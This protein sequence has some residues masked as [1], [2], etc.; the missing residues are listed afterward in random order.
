VEY[1][2]FLIIGGLFTPHRVQLVARMIKP[3]CV[4]SRFH[5]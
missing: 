5:T 1:A 4:N 2:F 3:Q